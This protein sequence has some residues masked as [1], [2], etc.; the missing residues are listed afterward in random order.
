MDDVRNN[1]GFLHLYPLSG[2]A[3]W[4]HMCIHHAETSRYLID[5]A[6]LDELTVA[7]MVEDDT[8]SRLQQR[9]NGLM[10]LLKAM[11][12]KDGFMAMPEDMVSIRIWIDANRVITAREADVD[13]II[14]LAAR[15][16]R[17]QGA[18]RPGEF[19]TDLID[20]H[21]GEVAKQMESLEDDVDHIDR[22]LVQHQMEA[23][24]PSM[25]ET[26]TR[27][28]GFLRHLGPQRGV[29]ES[30]VRLDHPVLTD[31][32]RARL[33]DAL[34]RLLQFL[35]TLHNLRD[36]V[37]ILNDQVTRIQERRLARSSY[38]F[39]VV[40]TIFLPLNFLTGLFGMNLMG[41]PFAESAQGFWI[42]LAICAF[43][44][45]LLL[46]AFRWRKWL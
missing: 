1:P 16:A 22:L 41:L 11:H 15:V 25:A 23:A 45:T 29:L 33:E 5:V 8:R 35:E 37:D 12:L 42:M 20:E 10:V 31:Q 18:V 40:A 26:Q 7:A 24:C 9:G 13:P 43:L 34:S 38:V 32:D 46:L 19:L 14:E 2:G 39:A 4:L 27:I 30:L 6:G 21:L 17:G 36:R 44:V 28:S 3:Q